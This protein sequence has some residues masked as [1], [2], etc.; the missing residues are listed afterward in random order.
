MKVGNDGV[1]SMFCNVD[2]VIAGARAKSLKASYKILRSTQK[3][4]EEIA[5]KQGEIAMWLGVKEEADEYVKVL[6]KARDEHPDTS[7]EPL[8][9]DIVTEGAKSID[10]KDYSNGS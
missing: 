9:P 4:Q 3:L 10:E 8:P 7:V 1:R 6:E 5:V 2:E